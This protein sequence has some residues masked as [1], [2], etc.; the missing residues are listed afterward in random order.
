MKPVLGA[1]QDQTVA[2]TLPMEYVMRV[3]TLTTGNKKGDFRLKGSEDWIPASA[4]MTVRGSY[5]GYSRSNST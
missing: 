2:K 4:G 1:L 3:A 5:V